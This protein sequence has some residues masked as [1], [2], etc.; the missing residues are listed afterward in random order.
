MPRWCQDPHRPSPDIDAR[1]AKVIEQLSTAE[2][3]DVVAEGILSR[4]HTGPGGTTATSQHAIGQG[5]V[6]LPARLR[7]VVDLRSAGKNSPQHWPAR[8]STRSS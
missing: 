3:D 6:R 5:R 1:A 2:V 7:A 8:R 4:H